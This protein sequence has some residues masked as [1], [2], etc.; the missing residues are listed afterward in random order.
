MIYQAP[1][2]TR[3]AAYQAVLEHYRCNEAAQLQRLLKAAELPP[4]RAQKVVESAAA[5]VRGVRAEQAH[6][7]GELSEPAVS[8]QP[9][10]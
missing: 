9:S 3:E 2:Q 8:G 6:G 1:A 4:A 7:S 5:L 10:W